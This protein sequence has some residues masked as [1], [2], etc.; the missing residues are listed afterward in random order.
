MEL[1][2]APTYTPPKLNIALAKWWLEDDRFLLG[3]G[4]FY[5]GRTVKLRGGAPGP[6]D[7]GCASSWIQSLICFEQPLETAYRPLRSRRWWKPPLPKRQN[8]TGKSVWMFGFATLWGKS[9]VEALSTKRFGYLG[10][11]SF[12]VTRNHAIHY[13]WIYSYFNFKEFRSHDQYPPWN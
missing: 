9:V 6:I 4:L 2:R 10:L 8:D 1:F 13:E 7:W 5:Q 11:V 12:Y 3:P